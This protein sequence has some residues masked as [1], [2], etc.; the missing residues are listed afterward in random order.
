MILE[1]R[2]PL[3]Y[4]FNLIKWDIVLVAC[5]VSASYVLEQQYLKIELPLSFSGFLGTSITLLLS[6]KLSQSY[7]R[8]WEARK[9]WGAIVNDSRSFVTQ[10]LNYTNQ[11][12]KATVTKMALRQIA[13]CYLFADNLREKDPENS[14][15]KYVPE[16]EKDILRGHNHLP[17]SILN[18]HSND[19][20]NLHKNGNLND[21]QQMQID[22][23]IVRLCESMGK[24]E[25]IKKT[26]FPKTYRLTLRFFIFVFLFLLSLSF[27]NFK[28]W[29]GIPV[30]IVISIP[31]LLL[32]KIAKNVQ[33]PFS[34]RPTDCP[35]GSISKTIEL[36]IKELIE[37]KETSISEDS[38]SFY[39]M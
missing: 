19:L 11:N 9:I 23:T 17:L 12:A 21:F 2:V 10:L 7:D 33:D 24:A 18:K 28:M 25:R 38:N 31:F 8:W 26:I 37:N 39:E 36:N 29:I 15:V 4:W 16:D 5:F 6:F 3:K 22:S 32:E 35:I 20:N 1:K 27:M 13:W 30:L 34:N 14:I